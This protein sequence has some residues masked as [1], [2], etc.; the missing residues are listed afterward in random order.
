[1]RQTE[2]KLERSVM[3]TLRVIEGLGLVLIVIG[4]LVA[5]GLEIR[6]A[7]ADGAVSLKDILLLFIYLEVITMVGLY[8]SSGKLPL[9]Y[10][11]YI[12]MVAV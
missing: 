4:T 10:T 7:M 5:I 6:R 8:Y 12:A 1:M 2:G 3:M 9:R 11:L